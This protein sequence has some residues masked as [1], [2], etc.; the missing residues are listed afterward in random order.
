MFRIHNHS[1]LNPKIWQSDGSM[2]PEVAEVLTRTYISFMTVLSVYANIPIDLENDVVDVFL[3]G[4]SVNYFYSRKSDLD[5]KIFIK[6]DRYMEKIKPDLVNNFIRFIRNFFVDKYKPDCSGISID[7]SVTFS[8]IPYERYSLLQKKWVKEPKRLSDDELKY[9]KHRAK[10][11]YLAMDNM[12][13]TIVKDKNKHKDAASLYSYMKDRRFSSWYEKFSNRSPYSL[14]F[15]RI[16]KKQLEKLL[17]T[18][19]KYTKKLM[20][21]VN[22]NP[23]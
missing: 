23:S 6:P 13:K 16:K 11:Y 21:D 15:S 12:I 19:R 1:K 3:C 5:L 4:S 22:I 9:I 10:L 8:D 7:I 17:K 18:E 2:R 14:A 20:T